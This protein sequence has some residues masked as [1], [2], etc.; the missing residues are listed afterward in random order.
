MCSTYAKLYVL[1]KCQ[2][3]CALPMPNYSCSS[4]A[5]WCVLYLFYTYVLYL[6]ASNIFHCFGTIP[7]ASVSFSLDAPLQL[8]IQ[9]IPPALAAVS[10][11]HK[12]GKQ[13]SSTACGT[14]ISEAK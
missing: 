12:Q 13:Y 6:C 2:M 8:A 14:E 3:M 9:A 1:F 10:W 4:Y 5:K 11:N 7:V